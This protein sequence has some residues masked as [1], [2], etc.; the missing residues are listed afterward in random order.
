MTKAT[1]ALASAELLLGNGDVD[2]ACNR[3][4]YAMF[5]AARAALLAIG[6]P[7]A[8]EIAR[9]HSGLITSFSLHLVKPGLI[10]VEHGRSLN[11]VEDLRLIA[12]YK[13]DPVSLE[14][15]AWA[16]EQSHNFLTVVQA[17]VDR[18]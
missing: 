10:A 18:P 9:T 13:G 2:G 1:R 17:L 6:A 4:Y 11:K 16:V 3:A 8:A 5:D 15:A 7:V 14:N 12:D